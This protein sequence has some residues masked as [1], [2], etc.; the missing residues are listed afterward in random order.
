MLGEGGGRAFFFFFSWGVGRP[1]VGQPTVGPPTVGRSTTD[2]GE[3]YLLFSFKILTKVK[4]K[5]DEW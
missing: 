1:T 4:R 3:N 2:G 5:S